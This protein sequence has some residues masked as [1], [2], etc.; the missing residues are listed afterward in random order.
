MADQVVIHFILVI[1]QVIFS[2]PVLLTTF[3]TQRIEGGGGSVFHRYHLITCRSHFESTEAVFISSYIRFPL[4]LQ[5]WFPLIDVM[6]LTKTK[7]LK[8]LSWDEPHV[9]FPKTTKDQWLLNSTDMG[10]YSCIYMGRKSIFNSSKTV[11]P[12]KELTI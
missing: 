9:K 3:K 6:Y 1:I 7:G 11:S 5:V 2:C 4:P 10:I 8:H 12:L